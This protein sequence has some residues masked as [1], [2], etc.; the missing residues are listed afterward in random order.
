[1]MTSR[2]LQ[3]SFSYIFFGISDRSKNNLRGKIMKRSHQIHRR[4]GFLIDVPD[5]NSRA[6]LQESHDVPKLR[7]SNSKTK[8][9]MD[10]E[11]TVKESIFLIFDIKISLHCL[12]IEVPV[13]PHN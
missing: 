3:S 9:I 1:M 6:I 8:G 5:N 13:L 12:P 4:V 2:R 7:V 11:N 10:S